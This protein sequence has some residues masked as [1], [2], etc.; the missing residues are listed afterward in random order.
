MKLYCERGFI[1]PGGRLVAEGDTFS[2][3]GP[4]DVLSSTPRRAQP[5][6]A[7]HTGDSTLSLRPSVE[8]KT[9]AVA[10]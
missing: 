1:P 6:G 9:G 8:S 4:C 3:L 2:G 10:C 5:C 7:H